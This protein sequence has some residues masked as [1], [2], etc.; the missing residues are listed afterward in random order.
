MKAPKIPKI[1]PKKR[2]KYRAIVALDLI[3]FFFESKK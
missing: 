2:R 1:I 3:F